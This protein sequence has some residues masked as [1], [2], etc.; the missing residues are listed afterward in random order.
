MQ[1]DEVAIARPRLPGLCLSAST[2]AARET[3]RLASAEL[4]QPDMGLWMI[5]ARVLSHCALGRCRRLSRL[6]DVSQGH[7]HIAKRSHLRQHRAFPVSCSKLCRV[8]ASR[9]RSSSLLRIE[10][11]PWSASSRV[12]QGVRGVLLLSAS[13]LPWSVSGRVLRTVRGGLLVSAPSSFHATHLVMSSHLSLL[14]SVGAGQLVLALATSFR[15]S[16]L[17]QSVRR[18]GPL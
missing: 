11:L 1:P 6:R 9:V 16:G 17:S 18:S 5:C 15:A 4:R 7:H 10:D 12:H 3:L 13:A 14:C 2:W 8:R